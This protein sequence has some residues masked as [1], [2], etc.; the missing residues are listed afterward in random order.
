MH[1]SLVGRRSSMSVDGRR[2]DFWSHLRRCGGGAHACRVVT[3]V[4]SHTDML[5]MF[6]C[7]SNV[8]A[9]VRSEEI[10]CRDHFH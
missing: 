3:R 1:V 9:S 5:R 8:F 4:S 10:A 6:E 2:R 7:V